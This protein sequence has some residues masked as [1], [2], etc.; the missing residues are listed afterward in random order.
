MDLSIDAY[1]LAC[2]CVR[3]VANAYAPLTMRTHHTFIWQNQ[4][5]SILT[6]TCT[7]LG[8]HSFQIPKKKSGRGSLE[9]LTTWW[10]RLTPDTQQLVSDVGFG[11]VAAVTIHRATSNT[12][13]FCLAERWWDTTHTLHLAGRE[14]TLTPYDFH[15][16]TGLR[17]RG[18]PF[19]FELTEDQRKALTQ[20][21]LGMP[22]PNATMKYPALYN[23]FLGRGQDSVEER[24]IM[25]RAF[26]L[27]LIGAFLV[28]N[29]AQTFEPGWLLALEDLEAAYEYGW[30]SAV[31]AH[32][33]ATTD[34]LSRVKS[35]SLTGCWRLWAVSNRIWVPFSSIFMLCSLLKMFIDSLCLSCSYGPRSTLT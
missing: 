32:L 5:K 34:A 17:M 8:L 25:A 15:R 21:L 33:Y 13:V 19:T 22:C 26:I 23:E 10:D 35:D 20:R 28:P 7:Y 11:T 30:G 24:V 27:Y 2:V 29:A 14:W 1:A 18:R 12:L 9:S 3:T 16:L 4:S 6:C 31:L